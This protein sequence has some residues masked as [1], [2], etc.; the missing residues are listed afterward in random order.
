MCNEAVLAQRDAHTST[1]RV[2][3][4]SLSLII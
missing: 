2:G 3:Y 1:V 4:F